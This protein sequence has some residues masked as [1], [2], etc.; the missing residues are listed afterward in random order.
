LVP[1]ILFD[2]RPDRPVRA[3]RV[4]DPQRRLWQLQYIW[5]NEGLSEDMFDDGYE[6]IINIDF[7]STSVKTMAEKLKEKGPN[8]KYQLMDVRAM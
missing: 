6:N 7:S 3:S 8:F 1:E 5:F 4:Q 2:A